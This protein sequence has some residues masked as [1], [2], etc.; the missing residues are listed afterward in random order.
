MCNTFSVQVP[1]HTSTQWTVPLKNFFFK[2]NWVGDFTLKKWRSLFRQMKPKPSQTQAVWSVS[3]AQWF[4]TTDQNHRWPRDHRVVPPSGCSP[5]MCRC[6]E[7]WKYTCT[8]IWLRQSDVQ[9]RLKISWWLNS[10]GFVYYKTVRSSQRRSKA[11]EPEPRFRSAQAS[12]DSGSRLRMIP[13]WSALKR[14]RPDHDRTRKK[15]TILP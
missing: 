9:M 10:T 5:A 13:S 3:N 12:T 4:K 8:W 6:A 14:H 2:G 7:D 15:I 1:G 11:G